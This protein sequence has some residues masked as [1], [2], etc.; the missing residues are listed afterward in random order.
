MQTE[1]ILQGKFIVLDGPDGC[2]KSTQS[3]ML[4]DYL[5]KASANIISFRDPGDTT[6]GDQIR[7][8]LLD[9]KNDKMD[10]R[11][12][13]LL[14]MAARAQLWKE[15]I[16]K[17]LEQKKCVLMDRWLSST[18]AYQGYAGGFGIKNVLSIAEQS[19]ERL[20]PDLTIILD[21]DT[22]TAFKRIG[23]NLDRMEQKSN[24]Y[25]KKVRAGFGELAK[26]RDD[27]AVVNTKSDIDSTHNKITKIIREHFK[28]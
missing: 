17:A 7:T 3:K 12:E 19:L 25:H 22:E 10:T 27:F 28:L 8:I 23:S 24:E 5:T 21:I 6:I 4:T 9:P 1:Q 2:G 11:T 15:K 16:A 14:Y 18:C 26:D 20:W 13:L